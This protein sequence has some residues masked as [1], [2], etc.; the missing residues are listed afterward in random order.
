MNDF[1]IRPHTW[2]EI[3]CDRSGWKNLLQS[4]RTFDDIT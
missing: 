4:K 3:S 2:T 1:A